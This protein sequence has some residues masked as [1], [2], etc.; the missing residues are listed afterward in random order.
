MSIPRI[1]KLTGKV[2]IK[3][4]DD[5]TNHKLGD[6]MLLLNDDAINPIP[7][8]YENLNNSGYIKAKVY[9]GLIWQNID[10]KEFCLNKEYK[11]SKKQR[12]IDNA[13]LC[14]EIMQSKAN[15]ILNRTYRGHFEITD[16]DF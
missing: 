3:Y 4:I 8:D 15:T 6:V 12:A 9:D 5:I 11:F 16:K 7:G 10:I 14:K 1:I 2:Y 13:M